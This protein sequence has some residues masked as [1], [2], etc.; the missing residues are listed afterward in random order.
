MTHRELYRAESIPVF[1]NKMFW[2][3]ADALACLKGD[4]VLVQDMSS[5]LVFN[6]AFDAGLL[7]YDADYQNE[8]ACSGIFQRHLDA[9]TKIISRNLNGKTLIEVGCG[10]GYFL[11]HLHALGYQ[12]TGIDPAYEGDSPHVIKSRFEPGLGLTA[13]GIVLRHML[14]HIPDPVGFLSSI[15]YANKGGGNIYIEV[16][17]FDWICRQGAWFDIFYE[18]VNYFRLSDFYRM[19]GTIHEA[20]H[21]FG[22]QY[23]YVLA[24][25]ATLRDPRLE[26]GDVVNFPD[27]FLCGIEH[28]ARL[29]NTKRRKAIWGAASKGMIFA[30]YMKRR[31]IELD[32]AI[33]INPAK[34]GRFLGGSGLRVS[35]PEEALCNL[36]QGGDIFIMNSNYFDEIVALSGNKFNYVPV[37]QNRIC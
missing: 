11:N 10:K 5:G 12:I 34:Q 21:F 37:D 18:H 16:P 6:S 23:L 3:Q 1:Q 13:D 19:F 27:N 26:S 30:M 9:V 29:A 15:A 36:E 32:F 24:D 7:E 28:F 35:S 20:G 22:G 31:V 17:C 8:Q 14:E 4:V 2:T 33:D 25:L